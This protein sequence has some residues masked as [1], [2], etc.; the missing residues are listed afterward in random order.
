LRKNVENA[1]EN[2]RNMFFSN[3]RFKNYFFKAKNG[4]KNRKLRLFCQI[5]AIFSIFSNKTMKNKMLRM[6]SKLLGTF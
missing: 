2:R 6:K 1:L 5:L 4:K 3:K